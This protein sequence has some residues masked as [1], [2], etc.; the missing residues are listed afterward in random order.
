MESQSYI[1]DIGKMNVVESTTDK[2]VKP[3]ARGKRHLKNPRAGQLQEGAKEFT[4]DAIVR[5]MRKVSVRVDIGKGEKEAANAS[6]ASTR[7]VVI[8]ISSKEKAVPGG[9]ITN[10][11]LHVDSE[12]LSLRL[13]ETEE[14]NGED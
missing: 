11:I 8:R 6:L 2:P 4:E 5:K 10:G 3:H 1:R 7:A 12:E 9:N 14:L 13:S